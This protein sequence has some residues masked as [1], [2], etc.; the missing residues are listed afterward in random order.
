VRVLLVSH[1]A[2]RTGAPR[3]AILVARSLVQ[4]GHALHILSRARGRCCQTSRQ[5]HLARVPESSVTQTREDPR[6]PTL[7]VML[8]AARLIRRRPDV[9]YVNSTAAAVYLRRAQWLGRRA[10][11]HVHESGTLAASFLETARAPHRLS[12]ITLVAPARPGSIPTCSGS[13]AK[14]AE[15]SR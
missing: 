12:G 3:V 2:S 13:P 6:P 11:L 8:A 1:E 14:A 9:V 10:V 5:Q 4:Q 7:G 15:T